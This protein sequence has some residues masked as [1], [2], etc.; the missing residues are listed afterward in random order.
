MRHLI[1]ACLFTAPA[2]AQTPD[3][4]KA[5]AET[6]KAERTAALKTFTPAE[7]AAAEELFA[8]AEAARAAGN[9]DSAMR[10]VV[11]AR[12]QVPFVPS[13]A[14]EHVLRILGA[15]RLRHGDRVNAIAYSPD[16]SRLVS[17]S[18]DGT[19]RVWDL[20]NGRE[21]IAYRGHIE[22]KAAADPKESANV[23]VVGGVAYSSDGEW[24]ASAGGS[25]IHVWEAKTG[26]LLHNLKGLK[27]PYK[28]VAFFKDK[29]K[30]LSG[31]DDRRLAIWDV[32]AGKT[33]FVTE[34]TDNNNALAINA[35]AISPTEKQIA[36]VNNAGGLVVYALAPEPKLV[37]SMPVSDEGKPVQSLVFTRD[38]NGIY[39]AG[40]DRKAKLSAGADGLPGAAAGSTVR[41]FEGHTEAVHAAAL[42]ADGKTLVTGSNDKSVIVWDAASAKIQRVFQG[43]LKE[44]TCVAV[45]PDGRQIA[46]GSEDGS[47]RLWPLSTSDD[48]KAVGDATDNL[49]TVAYSPDGRTFAA[50]GADRTIRIY[51][52]NSGKLLN[53]LKGHKGAVTALA[54]LAPNQL[55]STSGDKALKIWDIAA[56]SSKDCTGHTGAVL[57]VA[58]GGPWI[59]TGGTDKSIRGWNAATGASGFVWAG[60]SAVCAVAVR[61]DGRRIA[62]GCASGEVVLLDTDGDKEPKLLSTTTAHTAGVASL[63]F[64]NDGDR[65]A[66]AGGDGV[67]RLWNVAQN[68][69]PSQ[70]T[71]FDQTIKT[72]T[73]GATPVTGIAFSADDKFIVGGG[74]EG[75]VRIWDVATGGEM[76]VLRAHTGW[77]TGV[78]Y[79]PDGRTVLSCSVDQTARLFDLPRSE[80]SVPGHMGKALSIAVSRDGKYAA[81]GSEDKTVKVWDLATG[82]EIATLS[83]SEAHV[84][85]VTFVG[86][87][88]VAA[89]TASRS[90]DKKIRVWNFTNGREL[91][92]TPTATAISMAASEDG[93]RIGMAWANDGREGGFDVYPGLSNKPETVKGGKINAAAISPDAAWG[94]TGSEDGIIR[95]WDLARKER[96]GGDWPILKNAI[97]DIGF[98]PDRKFVVV[99]D[100]TG[101][102]QVADVAKREKTASVKAVAT[103]VNGVCV[104]PT[105]DKFATL[106]ATGEVKVWDMT[107]K[108]LRKWQLPFAANGAV[109]TI[110]G[111]KL[112]TANADGT[113]F[114]LEMP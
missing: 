64:T 20:G 82:R 76:K 32:P 98:T 16:G 62:V 57:C 85:A 4:W 3:P 111:K 30:L 1:L 107:C 38:G 60:K 71:K 109:F 75:V 9:A 35:V 52:T 8:K 37:L 61:K 87:D 31:G 27:G 42:T 33:A 65:L 72:G 2:F 81:T 84:S 66:T 110:D 83:G 58:P 54:F 73:S 26:K 28:S 99:I 113:A 93:S 79:A 40:N 25:E 88:Q 53:T 95:I 6:Y 74:A 89:G 23:L 70:L 108:E 102:V 55:A 56:G 90:A 96:L 51:D 63:A 21:V 34:D 49:W 36:S 86:K 22:T 46:S 50:A 47:I 45:R 112:L 100:D 94:V 114:V 39:T 41:K 7:L 106:S 11:E 67:V 91:F 12:W 77:V 103:G 43:H 80:S 10:L 69:A 17:A 24:I 105:G 104:A 78:A 68:S 44:V 101:E 29:R 5:A 59:V 13:G 19:V 97:A 18:R 15:G 14:P 48:H 92:S